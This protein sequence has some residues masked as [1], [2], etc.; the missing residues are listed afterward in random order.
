MSR[1]VLRLIARLNVGGPAQHVVWLARSLAPRGY[2]TLL[3]AGDVGRGEEE[4]SREF[5]ARWGVRFRR[6]RELGRE[7]RPLAD[8]MAFLRLL[9]LCLRY[10]P[11]IV[12]THTAKAGALGRAAALAGALLS[13][14]RPAI[15]HTYHGH[16]F[17]GYFGRAKTI[18]YLAVERTLARFSDALV[19]LSQLQAKDLAGTYRIAP[20]EKFRIVPLGLD[21]APFLAARVSE[22]R[23]GEARRAFGIAQIPPETPLV[24]WVGRLA[25]VKR[26]ELF[27]EAAAR[28][29]ERLPGA[30]FVLVGEGELRSRVER[31]IR[32]RGLQ[33][34]VRLAGTVRDLAPLYADLDVL[35]LTS[36]NEGTPLAILEAFAAGVP[37]VATAV[38]GVP[39]LLA[40]ERGVLVPPGDAAALAD[41]VSA[42]LG[43]AARAR[44]ISERARDYVAREHDLSSLAER[45]GILYAEILERKGI[46][47][48]K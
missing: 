5:L 44:A 27:V 31:A 24:G 11:D 46:L 10:R 48:W 8:F 7:I 12:H 25:P 19:V 33:D 36:A 1:R 37:V 13:G 17:E 2:S 4:L 45:T 18:F 35:A 21:L 23:R 28:I 16:V 22:K 3:A 32:E 20:P 34:S 47:E 39:D 42:L 15:V 40:G 26:P 43:D 9:S 41:A 38:G 14:R 30:R 29:R 6:I